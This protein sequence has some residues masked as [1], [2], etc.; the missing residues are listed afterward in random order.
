[1]P[2]SYWGPTY[3]PGHRTV[4]NSGLISSRLYIRLPARDILRKDWREDES[5]GAAVIEDGARTLTRPHQ[6][7]YTP[8]TSSGISP[9]LGRLSP[10]HAANYC[11]HDLDYC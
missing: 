9:I 7:Y 10:C 8:G 1:M 6:P 3:Q 2:A 4:D 5:I 11:P